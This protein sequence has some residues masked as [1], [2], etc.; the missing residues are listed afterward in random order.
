MIC[1]SQRVGSDSHQKNRA[2]LKDLVNLDWM[3]MIPRIVTW[4]GWAEPNPGRVEHLVGQMEKALSNRLRGEILGSTIEKSLCQYVS[5]HP[6]LHK[7]KAENVANAALYVVYDALVTSTCEMKG[8]DR[9]IKPFDAT[10]MGPHRTIPADLLNGQLTIGTFRMLALRQIF[11][12]QSSLG[13]DI[14]STLFHASNGFL[15]GSLLP[16]TQIADARAAAGMRVMKGGIRDEIGSPYEDII[17]RPVT[18]KMPRKRLELVHVRR[19]SQSAIPD[20]ASSAPQNVRCA[21]HSQIHPSGKKLELKY[22]VAHP[23]TDDSVQAFSVS[24]TESHVEPLSKRR[25][26]W[27]D[28]ANTIATAVHVNPWDLHVSQQTVLAERLYHTATTEPMHWAHP[29][30][31]IDV[32]EYS[33]VVVVTEGNELARIFSAT[34]PEPVKD[35]PCRV[36]IRHGGTLLQCID[37][38]NNSGP[39]WSLVM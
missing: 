37:A 8:C 28:A 19:K 21:V 6:E 24:R 34:C 13:L 3:K 32:D 29:L 22:F 38:A 14:E 39:Q 31:A 16:W 7:M 9:Y 36:V 5:S 33:R 23:G 11:Q 30:T 2:P 4:Y 17:E 35:R 18:S 20:I 10:E 15:I 12:E 26:S 25:V 1:S 27:I